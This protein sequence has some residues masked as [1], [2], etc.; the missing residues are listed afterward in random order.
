MQEQGK[1]LHGYLLSY[2]VLRLMFLK[3]HSIVTALSGKREAWGEKQKN[4]LTDLKL[5][6]S[7]FFPSTSCFASFWF[8]SL[9]FF[10][11]FFPS[12]SFFGCSLVFVAVE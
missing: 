12:P 4:I 3:E 2:Y 11:S 9:S 8:L 7:P 5:F 6:F 1:Y 10:R